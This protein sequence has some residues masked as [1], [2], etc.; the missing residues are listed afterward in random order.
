M[1]VAVG[2]AEEPTYTQVVVP[3]LLQ[4]LQLVWRV[5]GLLVAWLLVGGYVA[6]GVAVHQGRWSTLLVGGM[7]GSD[8]RYRVQG[9]G[10]P[11]G[12]HMASSSLVDGGG[13]RAVCEAQC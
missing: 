8:R 6:A 13:W 5:A 2:G 7:G 9:G 4:L 10:T 1:M 12:I 3:A 11:A